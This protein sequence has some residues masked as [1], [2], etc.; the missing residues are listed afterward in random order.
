M[1]TWTLEKRNKHTHTQT[2]THTHTLTFTHTQE[3]AMLNAPYGMLLYE[4][5]GMPTSLYVWYVVAACDLWHA[6]ASNN[7]VTASTSEGLPRSSI[8]ACT[9]CTDEPPGHTHKQT[10][11][12]SNMIIRFRNTNRIAHP[13][14]EEHLRKIN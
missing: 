11:T 14:F 12:N 13:S 5:Y 6:M 2:R 1:L 9:R 3:R 4:P 7:I 10:H 8:F